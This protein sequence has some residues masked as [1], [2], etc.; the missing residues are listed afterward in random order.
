VHIVVAVLIL[1]AVFAAVLAVS[2]AVAARSLSHAAETATEAADRAPGRDGLFARIA[3]VA[4]FLLV[5][6]VSLGLIGGG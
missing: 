6:G 3:F 5:G 1:G 2:V 4:L